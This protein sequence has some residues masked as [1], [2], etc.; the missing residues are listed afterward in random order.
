MN[1]SYTAYYKKPADEWF[2]AMPL[3]CGSRGAMVLGQCDKEDILLNQDTLWAGLPGHNT[4]CENKRFIAP[5]RELIN[6]GKYAE[7]SEFVENFMIG[8]RMN[9]YSPLGHIKINFSHTDYSDYIRAL[10][11]S[12]AIY[13]CDYICQNAKYHRE[14]FVSHPHMTFAQKFTCEGGKL[15]FTV[16]VDSETMSDTCIENGYIKLK[17]RAP[18]SNLS[19]PTDPVIYDTSHDADCVKFQAWLHV[20]TDGEK[21]YGEKEITV[22]GASYAVLYLVSDTSYIDWKTMPRKDPAIDCE[23]FMNRARLDGYDKMKQMHID[24]YKELFDRVEITL[25]K[26]TNSH[27]P[28]D[29]RLAKFAEDMSDAELCALYYNFGRYLTICAEREDS[30]PGNLQGIWSWK[31]KAEWGSDMHL[32]INLQMNYWP[33]ENA[34]LS[35]CRMSLLRWLKG[36]HESGKQTAY[37]LHGC[38]GSCAYHISNIWC[39][40]TPATGCPEWSYWPFGEAWLAMDIFDHYEYTKDIKF[41]AEYFDILK[42]NALFLYDWLYF[43]E[44]LGCFVTSPATTPENQFFYVDENGEKKQSSVS[45]ATTCDLAITREIFCDFIKASEILGRD[46]DFAA[47]VAEKLDLIYPYQIGEKGDLLEWFK[48]FEQRELGHRHMSHMLG[49]Y[50]GSFINEY[51]TPELFKAVEKSLEI[52]LDNGSGYTGWSCAWALAFL[53]KFRNTS[54]ACEYIKRLFRDSTSPNLLDLH[55]PHIFQIDGNFGVTAA[56]GEMLVQSNNDII[57]LFPCIPDIIKNG[58]FKGLRAKGAVTVN[59]EWQNGELKSAE[60]IPDFY[61]EYSLRY[62]DKII[63]VTAKAGETVKVFC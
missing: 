59:A 20:D 34:N 35:E 55:P 60:I 36:L 2:Q 32:N 58:K 53:A 54:R 7:A 19:R 10:D 50:P 37:E 41:L 57:E 40:T 48:D 26:G 56:I 12:N 30:M 27:L 18:V 28:T 42:D 52:R 33:A 38:R 61:G 44:E 45:K 25:D 51:D 47:S 23:R 39:K 14:G 29:E 5:A 1:T 62:R 24:D 4:K 43:D 63:T 13:T 17:G 16:T 11:L 6:A 15:N 22:N 31:P 3:G 21:V 9:G 8:E 46:E 49:V